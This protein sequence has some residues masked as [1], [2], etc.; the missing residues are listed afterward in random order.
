M[1]CIGLTKVILLHIMKLNTEVVV[2]ME[3]PPAKKTYKFMCLL[4]ELMLLVA[5]DNVGNKQ[6]F[7]QANIPT[8]RGMDAGSALAS[9]KSTGL[10]ARIF[11]DKMLGLVVVWCFGYFLHVK[12]YKIMMVQS[13]MKI[14]ILML[15]FSWPNIWSLIEDS[16]STSGF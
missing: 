8:T 4:K 5:I 10:R 1:Y 12:K 13:L 16:Y 9:L 2:R 14:F 11:V 3:D 7:C 6:P 15:R